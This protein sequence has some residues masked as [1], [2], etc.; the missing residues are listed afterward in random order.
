MKCTGALTILSFVLCSTTAF[1]Q[2]A[3]TPQ[4]VLA[5]VYRGGLDAAKTGRCNDNTPPQGFCQTG[6]EVDITNNHITGHFGHGVGLFHAM[7]AGLP[8]TGSWGLGGAGGSDVVIASQEL[9]Q[10]TDGMISIAIGDDRQLFVKPSADGTRLEGFLRYTSKHNGVMVTDT[11]Y[12]L[13]RTSN[14]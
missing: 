1:G 6:L 2:Q 10:N 3:T 11:S 7:V 5:G 13:T 12:T 8:Y 4:P 14:S 9:K